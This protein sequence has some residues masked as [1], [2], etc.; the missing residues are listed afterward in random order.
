VRDTEHA[1]SIVD[2]FDL[3][4][5]ADSQAMGFLID[6]SPYIELVALFTHSAAHH[7]YETPLSDDQSLNVICDEYVH[8]SATVK[9][10]K[11]LRW[12][13]QGFGSQVKILQPEPLKTFFAEEAKALAALYAY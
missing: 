8:L 5:F 13:L 2:G 9:N 10:T 4:A 12:W 11:E 6:A 7:F 1:A 3:Q